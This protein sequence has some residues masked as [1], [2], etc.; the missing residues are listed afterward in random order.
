MNFRAIPRELYQYVHAADTAAAFEDWATVDQAESVTRQIDENEAN[1]IYEHLVEDER[2]LLRSTRASDQADQAIYSQQQRE[3]GYEWVIDENGDGSWV[4]ASDPAE[5]Y[6]SST[7]STPT[8]LT[9]DRASDPTWGEENLDE[10]AF[11]AEYNLNGAFGSRLGN[12]EGIEEIGLTE[13]NPGTMRG[14]GFERENAFAAIGRSQNQ[15]NSNPVNVAWDGNLRNQNTNGGGNPTMMTEGS[16]VPVS[17]SSG[18]GTQASGGA[19]TLGGS[20]SRSGGSQQQIVDLWGA[21][22]EYLGW[23]VDS[24]STD[25]LGGEVIDSTYYLS[26]GDEV[27]PYPF[28]RE[29]P[30]S[31]NN[32]ATDSQPPNEPPQ[33]EGKGNISSEVDGLHSMRPREFPFDFEGPLP[34]GSW[35]APVPEGHPGLNISPYHGTGAYYTIDG[36]LWELS[37]EDVEDLRRIRARAEDPLGTAANYFLPFSETEEQFWDRITLE[38]VDYRLQWSHNPP[39]GYVADQIHNDAA[40]RVMN[41]DLQRLLQLSDTFDLITLGAAG[42]PMRLGKESL[43]NGVERNVK[44]RL[45]NGAAENVADTLDGSATRGAA[46]ANQLPIVNQLPTCFVAGTP[47]LTPS[48]SV[49]IENLKAGDYVWA[50]S[51]HDPGGD[52]R[53]QRIEQTFILEAP[54]IAIVVEGHTI[55]T[56]PDHP[57]FV[58][59]KGWVPARELEENDLL[60]GHNDVIAPISSVFP[61]GEVQ[62]VYNFRVRDDHTYFVGDDGWGFSLWV[63]NTYKITEIDGPNGERLYQ[64]IDESTGNPIKDGTFDDPVKAKD[65]LEELEDFS[66]RESPFGALYGSFEDAAGVDELYGVIKI[67]TKDE[68]MFLNGFKQ[69]WI[70]QTPS[71]RWVTSFYNRTLQKFTTAKSSSHNP[72]Y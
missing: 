1:R 17:S 39:P 47:I 65:R 66:V 51:E 61:T 3:A 64:I 29:V 24:Y 7:V 27:P 56:T 49:P 63:H 35:R 31:E 10:A 26:N 70:G 40:R 34:P 21:G 15:A 8:E 20:F 44:N 48:G 32:S 4:F 67:E 12:G 38:A 50:R 54:T 43:E 23:R 28:E 18:A 33:S 58:A 9:P 16:P 60:A 11:A 22:N 62:T 55:E 72:N 57:F 71:G 68:E 25:P 53:P 30:L 69:K 6:Q 59:G 36:Q 19:T 42:I 13:G 5:R 46:D 45:K 2:E 14:Q 41:N 37:P 52:I